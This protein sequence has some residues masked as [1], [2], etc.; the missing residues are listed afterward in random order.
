MKDTGYDAYRYSFTV[1]TVFRIVGKVLVIISILKQKNVL[2]NN[3]YFLV[4]HLAIC[5][6]GV[7]IIFFFSRI[8]SELSEK[9]KLT[10]TKFYC[11]G[12][13]VMYFFQFSVTGMM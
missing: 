12:Y 13:S 6:L 2:K 3:Y 9:S 8:V 4:L 10:G 11:L 1:V 5:D 7:L